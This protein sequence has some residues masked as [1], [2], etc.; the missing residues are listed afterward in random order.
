MTE[1][2]RSVDRA[3]ARQKVIDGVGKGHEAKNRDADP[4]GCRSPAQ[5]CCTEEKHHHQICYLKPVHRHS[6]AR[7]GGRV[8]AWAAVRRADVSSAARIW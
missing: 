1:V 2:D 4:F 8:N 7:R 6:V 3:M 5:C